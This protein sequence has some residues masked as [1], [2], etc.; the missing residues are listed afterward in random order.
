MNHAHKTDPYYPNSDHCRISFAA[1]R[2]WFFA[3]CSVSTVSATFTE[4]LAHFL[5][6]GTWRWRPG[7][8]SIGDYRS[9]E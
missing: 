1:S 4:F 8:G 6:L 9:Q 5:A 3:T 2:L 7:S